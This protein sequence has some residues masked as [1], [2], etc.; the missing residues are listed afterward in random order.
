[1]TRIRKVPGRWQIDRKIPVTLIVTL[2]LAVAAQSA[3]AIW[4][5]GRMDYRVELAEKTLKAAVETV[6]AYNERLIRL[7][8][9]GNQI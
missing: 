5:A 8:T 4:W 1:M 9:R 3:A 7:E 2:V 6:G